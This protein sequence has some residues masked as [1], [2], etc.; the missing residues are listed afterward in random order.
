[1][2]FVKLT[3]S[4]LLELKSKGFNVL[5]SVTKIDSEDPT[6]MPIKVDDIWAFLE[7]LPS[8]PL[9]EPHLLVIDE[10]LNNIRE[11]DLIGMVWV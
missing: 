11:E 7:A 8:I 5:T 2:E 6:Y 1:M 3:H 10:A 4:V 9:E